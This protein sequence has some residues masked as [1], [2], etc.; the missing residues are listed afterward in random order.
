MSFGSSPPIRRYNRRVAALMGGYVV[1]LVGAEKAL[2]QPGFAPA[3]RDAIAV[4]PALPVIGMFWAIGRLLVEMTDEYQRDRFVRQILW[5][6]AATLSVT[7]AWGFL[8]DVSGL[9]H[10]NPFFTA[11]LWFAALG[12]GACVRWVA[13]R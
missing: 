4:L 6:T 12:L 7:T 2:R 5:A 9:P 13:E 8:E 10:F 3:L 11:V 1:L